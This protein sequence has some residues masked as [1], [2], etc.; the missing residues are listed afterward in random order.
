MEWGVSVCVRVL[1]AVMMFCRP[2]LNI[3]MCVTGRLTE[4]G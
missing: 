3:C 2:S 1:L 4:A